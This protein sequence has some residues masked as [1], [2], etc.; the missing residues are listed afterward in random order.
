ML[1]YFY[2]CVCATYMSQHVP[3]WCPRDIKTSNKSA[4]VSQPHQARKHLHSQ[5]GMQCLTLSFTP[6][7]MEMVCV[8]LLLASVNISQL[9]VRE[10]SDYGTKE[11]LCFSRVS[12][13]VR[14]TTFIQSQ[15]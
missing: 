14:L 13:C 1:I 3:V 9:V 8:L 10:K 11:Y 15:R 6:L 7:M 2:M 5:I 4:T 12:V